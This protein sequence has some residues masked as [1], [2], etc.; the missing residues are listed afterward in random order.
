AGEG[1]G[2]RPPGAGTRSVGGVEV[3]RGA[4][5]NDLG[6]RARSR[7]EQKLE[8]QEQSDGPTVRPSDAH[9]GNTA[10]VVR[11]TWI[12]GIA[13]PCTGKRIVRLAESR[14]SPPRYRQA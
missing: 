8:R 5:E 2:G 6:G 11:V 3:K 4:I 1:T 12:T 9:Y 10:T 13:T 7:E 14:D